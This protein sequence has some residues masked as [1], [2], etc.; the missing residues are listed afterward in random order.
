[1]EA[2][3]GGERLQIPKSCPAELYDLMLKM[4]S[5]NETQRPSFSEIVT[6]LSLLLAHYE[7]IE[8]EEQGNQNSNTNGKEKPIGGYTLSVD[9]IENE[10]EERRTNLTNEIKIA[11]QT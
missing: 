10:K 1:M 9:N 7:T 4:W 3:L 5:I 11:Q 6:T 8:D 2:L